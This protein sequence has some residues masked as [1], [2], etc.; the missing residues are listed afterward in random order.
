[1]VRT[2]K[3]KVAFGSVRH[4][5]RKLAAQAGEQERGAPQAEAAAAGPSLDLVPA[6]YD[7]E[8]ADPDE[9]RRNDTEVGTTFFEAKGNQRRGGGRKRKKDGP[10]AAEKAKAD[11]RDHP[12]L[13]HLGDQREIKALLP[14]LVP[15]HQQERAEIAED[16]AKGFERWRVYLSAGFNLCLYGYGSKR[17]LLEDFAQSHLTDGSVTIANGYMAE[18]TAHSVLL[19]AA[20]AVVTEADAHKLRNTS[21]EY[22]LEKI[23]EVFNKLKY[24][25]NYINVASSSR[26]CRSICR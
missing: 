8:E 1:M 3:G 23:R 20:M 15:G 17:S 5:S 10:T 16:L 25:F 12:L 24:Y 22:L 19:G 7:D 13:A 21:S 18:C 14:T 2:R 11:L 26:C 6:A 4:A 9:R